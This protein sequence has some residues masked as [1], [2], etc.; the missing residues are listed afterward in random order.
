[1]NKFFVHLVRLAGFDTFV[2]LFSA[3]VKKTGFR[4]QKS[5][6]ITSNLVQA[7]TDCSNLS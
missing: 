7:T 1:M 2:T 6:P 3:G 4:L 5:C